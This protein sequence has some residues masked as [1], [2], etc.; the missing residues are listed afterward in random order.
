MLCN[1]GKGECARGRGSEGREG[2]GEHQTNTKNHNLKTP[3][4]PKPP[5]PHKTGVLTVKLGSKGT[6]VINK[7]TP[8]RQIWLSSPV[9]GPFR[10][11]YAGG[12]R[13]VYS[14][15]GRELHRQIAEELLALLGAAPE[16][17]APREEDE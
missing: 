11:D 10:F 3:K 14:R 8:N 16:G 17:L 15:D 5:K 7:Q 1:K 2:E 13:W 12:G 9:S 6:Y 4:P